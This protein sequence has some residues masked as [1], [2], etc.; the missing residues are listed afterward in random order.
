MNKEIPKYLFHKSSPYNRLSIRHYGIVP[1]LGPS[2]IC[3]WNFKKG[4]KPLVFLYD[5]NICKYDTTYDDD[6]YRI[7]TT[8]LDRR[9]LTMDP[10]RTMVGCF[11]YS[12]VIHDTCYEIVYKGKGKDNS[13]QTNTGT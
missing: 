3:H 7:D 5:I 8:K 2:Y 6:I 12:A 4:L 13:I 1:Q 11:A 10:D 9:R